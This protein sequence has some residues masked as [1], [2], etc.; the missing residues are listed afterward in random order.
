LDLG[1]SSVQRQAGLY[2]GHFCSR[3]SSFQFHEHIHVGLE[4]PK[5]GALHE[6]V[7]GLEH[8]LFSIIYWECHHPNGLSDFS[9]G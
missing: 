8:F 6:L 9:E 5:S 4:I 7:G 2:M 3:N 1:A